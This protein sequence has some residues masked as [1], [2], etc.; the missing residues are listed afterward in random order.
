MKLYP[1]YINTSHVESLTAEQLS[2]A[3]YRCA[4]DFGTRVGFSSF[5]YILILGSITLFTDSGWSYFKEHWLLVIMVY[6]FNIGRMF[7]ARK[8]TR[9][10]KNHYRSY[11][12]SYY[13]LTLAVALLWGIIMSMMFWADQLQNFSYL[14]LSITIALMGGAN[15][16][17]TSYVRT[18]M[19]Y[20]FLIWLPIVSV[21]VLMSYNNVPNAALILYLIIIMLF[22]VINQARRIALDNQ[23]G[24]LRQILLETQSNELMLALRTIKQQQKEV[25]KH[26]D[27]LQDLVNEKTID[28][29]KAKEKAEQADK[30]KSEFLANMSHELR[31]PLHS[32]LSFSQFGLTRLDQLDNKKIRSYF[33]KI[34]Y[35]G[36]VQL[37]LVND[38]LDLS[39]LESNKEA[40]FFSRYN[41]IA[42]TKN[43]IDELSSLYEEKGIKISLND[44]QMII[45]INCDKNKIEQLLRNLIGNAIKFSPEKSQILIKMYKNTSAIRL[46]IEDQGPGIPDED[47]DSIFDKF[48]QS[49]RTRTGAGGTGLGLAICAQIM[50]HHNGDIWVEDTIEGNDHSGARFVVVFPPAKQQTKA[51][52]Q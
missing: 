9:A 51:I 34:N 42:I 14:L 26:R 24:T 33:E 11:L 38:L 5:V 39:R 52:I 41:L 27:H 50:Q 49:S 44:P 36:E 13:A 1:F 18:N 7:L 45:P 37:N 43:I 48:N 31:T 46:E 22:F 6:V 35:S 8:L 29:I 28:L 40:L 2:E 32:I 10:E 15:G 25:K 4:R 47:K 12:N 21:L 17:L 20:N 16:T 30:T 23:N 3:S 19:Q